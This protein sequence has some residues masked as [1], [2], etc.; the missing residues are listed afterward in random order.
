MALRLMLPASISCFRTGATLDGCAKV[1]QHLARAEEHLAVEGEG[2][3]IAA[4]QD[5]LVR[6]GRV[7]DDG[8]LGLVVDNQIGIVAAAPHP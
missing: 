1:D 3:A 6:V 2:P 7:D 8:V 4:R 5:L